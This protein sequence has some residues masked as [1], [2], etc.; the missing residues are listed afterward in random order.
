LAQVNPPERSLP[1]VK[2]YEDL[3]LQ[4]RTAL[5]LGVRCGTKIPYCQGG[6]SW[7]INELTQLTVTL[8]KS[9]TQRFVTQVK[10]FHSMP[11]LSLPQ[12][13]T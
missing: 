4:T 11:E 13:S 1:Q 5:R 9:G 3:A 2:R 8:D 7:R 12:Q 6:G 10:G